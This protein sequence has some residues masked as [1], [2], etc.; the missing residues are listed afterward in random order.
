[1]FVIYVS[2][3]GASFSLCVLGMTTGV[4]HDGFNAAS[5]HIIIQFYDYLSVLIDNS[6]G[7]K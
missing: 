4:Q 3:I 7:R 2:L 1:M 6:V 5:T